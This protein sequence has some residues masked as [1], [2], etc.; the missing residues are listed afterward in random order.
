MIN[1]PDFRSFE[2]SFQMISQVSGRAGRRKTKG[3][4]IIQSY[5]PEHNVIRF[6]IDNE[7]EAMYK[8][9]VLER[10]NFHYPPFCRIIKIS[11]K[12]KDRDVLREGAKL[13]AFELRK[14]IGKRILG[15]EYPIVSRVKTY[16]IKDILVKLEKN[17][18]L[19]QAKE[20]IQTTSSNILQ[21]S[22]FK[23]I[24][25]IYDVDPV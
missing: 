10:K 1:F 25:I 4:V 12:H 19:S 13:L 5:N 8:S 7:Y 9:Q 11:L 23:S 6:A 3:K 22:A 15:P 14:K 20:L 17:I 21:E 16:Y 18:N 2:R 24:R